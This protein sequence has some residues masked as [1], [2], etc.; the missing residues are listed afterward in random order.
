MT[1]EQILSAEKECKRIIN[2]FSH[3]KNSVENAKLSAIIFFN[4]LISEYK[5]IEK[6]ENIEMEYAIENYKYIINEILCKDN[7]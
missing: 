2:L 4:E 6:Y 1:I 5:S 7:Q 3:S